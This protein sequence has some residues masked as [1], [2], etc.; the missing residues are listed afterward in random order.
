VLLVGDARQHVSVEAGD[1][2]RV[3]E[4]HSQ[5]GQCEVAEIRRQE[6]PEYKR[7]IMQMAHGNVREGLHQLDAIDWLHEGNADYLQHAADAYLKLRQ[8]GAEDILVVAPTWRE[9][10]LLSESIRKGLRRIGMLQR[11]GRQ[12]TIFNPNRWTLQQK[13]NF[14]N[15]TP[16]QV[17]IFNTNSAGWNAGD[18]LTISRIEG[19]AV[20]VQDR[21]GKESVLKLSSAAAFEVGTLRPIEVTLNDK[22]LIRAN[23][24]KLGLINGQVL[25]AQT[26]NADG[27]I[28]TQEGISIPA[29]FKEWCHGY[30][31]TSHKS[32]GRTCEHVI[33]AAERLDAKAA[34]V[35]CSRGRRTCSIHTPDKARLLE[36]L[37]E[38][39][40][41]GA[42]DVIADNGMQN[43][44]PSLLN[45]AS[46]WQK[47]LVE[48]HKNATTIREVISRWVIKDEKQPV[49]R[50][51]RIR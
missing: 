4:A 36:R 40:R 25:T 46:I 51:I 2:L 6:A 42:L 41:K 28:E 43:I 19:K 11:A 7:A 22:I 34:Y 33:V 44:P 12:M 48:I 45:R 18:C 50:G 47:A 26:V 23:R 9:N 31:V 24:K 14:K 15:Y 20:V 35:A 27:T 37:P 49:S 32:Q 13:R 30:V 8:G 39:N 5:L 10:D 29:N 1:F 21:S 16:G 3:L 17:I 38:G